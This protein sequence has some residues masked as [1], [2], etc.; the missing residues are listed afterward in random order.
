[1]TT[2]KQQTS[3][4]TTEQLMCSLVDSRA[5]HTALLGKDLEK[6]MTAT[7]GRKCLGQFAKFNQ[8][9]FWAKTFMGL[10]IG[11]GDWF[12]KRSS[13]TWKLKGTKCNLLY[14]QL[15]AK[16]HHIEG[17]EFGLL[18]TP[19]CTDTNC[20]DLEKIDLRRKKAIL[21][22]KNG[23]GFGKT[24]GEMANRSTLPTP[25]TSDCVEKT[26]GLEKQDSLTKRTRNQTGKTSQLNP[27]FV[28]EMMG[29]PSNWTELP[30]LNGGMK[31]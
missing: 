4:F 23:N 7:S 21:K 20:G 31:V 3:L 30:F 16:T 6:Q 25:I 18:P 13:L 5:S 9:T 26:T 24:L 14:F 1:M 10:L 28:G 22:N 29:F 11:K 2:L 27:Q 19:I 17:T 8:A 12:S 15:I